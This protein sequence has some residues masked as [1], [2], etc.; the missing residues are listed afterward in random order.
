MSPLARAAALALFGAMAGTVGFVAAFGRDPGLAFEMDRDLPGR[1]LVGFHPAE[2]VGEESYAWTGERAQL[3]VAGLDTDVPW[4][5]TLRV[6]SGRPAGVPAPT[7]QLALDGEVLATHVATGEYADVGVTI[8][9]RADRRLRL[10]IT[11]SPTF[12][13]GPDDPRQLGAQVDRLAC[14]PPDGAWI[15]PPGGAM[16]SA[17]LAIAIFGAL[18]GWTVTSSVLALAATLLLAAVQSLPLSLGIGPYTPYAEHVVWLAFWIAIPAAAAVWLI[19]AWRP[20]SAGTGPP[21]GGHYYYERGVRF[22]ATFSAAALFVKLLALLHPSKA[23]VDA[24]FHAHRLD[25]V[26]GGR[27]FFTQLMPGDIQFPYAIALY[28]FAAPWASLTGDHVALLRVVVSASEAIAGVL[29]FWAVLRIWRDPLAAG[30]TLLLFHLLPVSYWVVGNANLTNAF[31]QSAAVAAM[32]LAIAWRLGARDWLQLLGLSLVAAVALL[33]HV[34]T[35]ALLGATMAL[36]TVFFAWAGGSAL[37]PVARSVAIA[38]ILAALTATALYYGRPEFYP[39]YESA[40]EARAVGAPDPE[41]AGV[42]GSGS[43]PARAVQG[44]LQSA[45]AVGWPILAL[46]LIGAWRVGVERRRDRLALA[47][48]GW[49]T[50]F[51]VFFLFGVAAPARVG[52]DRYALEFIVRAAYTASP[53]AIVLAGYGAAWS[54][55]TGAPL[56]R[57]TAVAL[58]TLAGLVAVAEWVGWLT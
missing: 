53:A 36:T 37:R 27:Y 55:R 40:R 39:A 35:F 57:T 19:H 23:I 11:A 2:I 17:A 20:G 29:L 8:P 6:R 28:V 25:Y 18:I 47:A 26:L 3:N 38:A 33:S 14:S 42:R 46:A 10:V 7:V 51:L 32:A 52:Q 4:R 48:A 16:A 43:L 50:A 49:L 31:G 22:A 41:T 13:P 56:I 21:K 1:V 24:V 44:V 58:L 9:P 30:L 15:L 12:V 5:C 34:S 54:W 45:D